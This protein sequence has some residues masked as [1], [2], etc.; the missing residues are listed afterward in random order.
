MVLIRENIKG[1]V[2]KIIVRSIFIISFLGW[3]SFVAGCSTKPMFMPETLRDRPRGELA[4]LTVSVGYFKDAYID[5]VKWP[6]SSW[7]GCPDVYLEPGKHVLVN[8]VPEFKHSA[9]SFI[10]SREMVK[11]DGINTTYR[12]KYHTVPASTTPAHTVECTFNFETGFVYDMAG[13]LFREKCELL[14]S[15]YVAPCVVWGTVIAK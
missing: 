15:D 7:S 11:T 14:P 6:C 9:Y 3:L 1:S 8:H 2:M 12:V 10:T 5:G 4:V 13:F